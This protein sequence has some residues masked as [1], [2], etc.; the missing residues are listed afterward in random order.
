MVE[1]NNRI[2]CRFCGQTFLRWTGPRRSGWPSLVRHMEEEHWD[3]YIKI[4]RSLDDEFGTTVV[5]DTLAERRA[6]ERELEQ[7]A[8]VE[9]TKRLLEKLTRRSARQHEST[10]RPRGGVLN[11]FRRLLG[12]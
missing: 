1:D 11:F 9:K 4:E 3:E 10:E 6:L 12:L 8:E 7:I 5:H 2:T